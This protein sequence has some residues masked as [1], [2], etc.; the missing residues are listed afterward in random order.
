MK[1]EM[2]MALLSALAAGEISAA[3]LTQKKLDSLLK[4]LAQKPAP[5]NLSPGAMCYMVDMPP[6]R[7]EYVCP[8]C[9]SKTIVANNLRW[10]IGNMLDTYRQQIKQVKRLGLSATLDER[11]M[12]E[13]CRAKMEPA[14][15]IGDFFIE[16][17]IGEKTTR[18]EIRQDDCPKLIAFLKKKDR[19]EAGNGSELPLKDELP[20]IR[21]IL[22]IQETTP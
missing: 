20:R 3:G 15:E 6:E 7:I 22:G 14:P 12:C 8:V 5:K 11:S 4:E 21:E 2:L 17:K 9:N 18:T 16:V 10:F 1:R 19:W 13:T